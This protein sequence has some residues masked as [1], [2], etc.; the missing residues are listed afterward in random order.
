MKKK[1]KINPYK[2]WEIY[3]TLSLLLV[4]VIFAIGFIDGSKEY[5]PNWGS[6]ILLSIIHALVVLILGKQFNEED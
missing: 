5:M 2:L 1:F 4:V 3:F 6:H